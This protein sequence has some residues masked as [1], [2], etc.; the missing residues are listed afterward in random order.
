MMALGSVRL[1]EPCG[2]VPTSR[3]E[4]NCAD[5]ADSGV[6]FVLFVLYNLRRVPPAKTKKTE[7]TKGTSESPETGF[8]CRGLHRHQQRSLEAMSRKETLGEK[9]AR[10]VKE[11][12]D[13]V[14][15]DPRWPEMFAQ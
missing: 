6:L 13:V 9:I 14:P 15:Y 4:L 1:C 5:P 10:V 7:R 8:A 12:V 3:L 2:N 11:Q